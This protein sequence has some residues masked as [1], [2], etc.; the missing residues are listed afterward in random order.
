[1]HYYLTRGDDKNIKSSILTP[2]N[3][4]IGLENVNEEIYGWAISRGAGKNKQK[5]ERYS[6]EMRNGDKI[7]I[8]PKGESKRIYSGTIIDRIIGRDIPKKIWGEGTDSK[9]D[10]AIFINGVKETSIDKKD[11]IKRLGYKGAPQGIGEL[12]CQ[13]VEAIKDVLK[14]TKEDSPKENDIDEG[15][16]ALVE[17]N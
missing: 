4:H 6:K 5:N 12:K 9:Y 2:I 8:W 15:K 7:I 16:S 10:C 3:K 17:K 1:M 13:K 14:Y 11:L